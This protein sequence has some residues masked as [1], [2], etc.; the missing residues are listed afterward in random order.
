MNSNYYLKLLLYN[1]KIMFITHITFHSKINFEIIIV[2]DNSPDKTYEVIFSLK[3]MK[4]F[5]L[6]IIIII[7][8]VLQIVSDLQKHYS[9]EKL[10]LLKR[11]GKLG[12]G[13]AYIDGAKLS[14]G[15]F[16][17]LMD[18]DFSHHVS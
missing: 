10:K 6:T 7:I 12:L 11:P 15:D 8:N 16:I 4:N 14:K 1:R 2:D 18:A 13:T 17:F 9:E 5:S 3:S